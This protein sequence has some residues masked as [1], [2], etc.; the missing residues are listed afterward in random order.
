MFASM[1]LMVVILWRDAWLKPLTNYELDSD[2]CKLC[3]KPLKDRDIVTSC[4][5]CEI[6]IMHNQCGTDHIFDKHNAEIEKKIKFHKERKLH[7]YQ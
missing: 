4:E 2:S 3:N 5:F 1:L 7:D 6:G